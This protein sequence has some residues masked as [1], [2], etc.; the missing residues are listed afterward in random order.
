LKER[1]LMDEKKDLFYTNLLYAA[2]LHDIGKFWQRTN[3]NKSEYKHPRNLDLSTDNIGKSGAHSKWSAEFFDKYLELDEHSRDAVLF[4]H[5]Q[6]NAPTEEVRKKALLIQIADRLSSSER[7]E[8]ESGEVTSPVNEPL[9]SIFSNIAN[10]KDNMVWDDQKLYYYPLKNLNFKLGDEAVLIPKAGKKS[11]ISGYNLTPDYTHLWESF[12]KELLKITNK[13]S[14]TIELLMQLLEKYCWAIP[15]AAYKHTPDISLYDHLKTTCAIA[16]CLYQSNQT[17]EELQ[18]LKNQILKHE[19]TKEPLFLLIKGDISGIHNFIFTIIPKFALKT[20][21]G[22]SIFLEFL[23]EG[24]ARTLLSE[25][26]L[27]ITNILYCGGGNFYLLASVKSEQQLEELRKRISFNVLQTIGTELYF[28]IDW[29][30]LT[31]SDFFPESFSR[32]W[33]EVSEKVNIKKHTQYSEINLKENYDLFFEPFEVGGEKKQCT[34]CHKEI[35]QKEIR[36]WEESDVCLLCDSFRTMV[37]SI[38][39]AENVSIKKSN[40]SN[41]DITNEIKPYYEILFNLGTEISF[42]EKEEVI[43]NM[44]YNLLMDGVPKIPFKI[45][46]RGIPYDEKESRIRDLDTLASSSQGAEKLAIVKMDVDSLGKI[47]RFGLKDNNTI[48]RI[49]TLSNMITRFFGGYLDELIRS[50]DKYN[51]NCYTIFAGGDDLLIVGAWSIIY[52]LSYKIYEEFRRFTCTNPNMTLS[53][54]LVLTNK[55]Y[56]IIRAVVDTEEALNRAK[57]YLKTKNSINLFNESFNWDIFEKKE[58]KDIIDLFSKDNYL[59]NLNEYSIIW[60][61]KEL[62]VDM[63]NKGCPR[64]ILYKIANSI[65]GLSGIIKNSL[66]GD[67]EIPKVWRLRYYLRDYFKDKSQ[68][69]SHAECLLKIYEAIIEKNLLSDNE[70]SKISKASVILV[71]VRWAELLTKN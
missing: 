7:K 37:D 9:I 67:L 20:L 17:Y 10:I 69:K 52:E 61:I 51:N 38:K 55:K 62:L 21:K 64:S 5:K 45:I 59:E 28:A 39:T 14:I 66:K 34:I 4:H 71:A 65:K 47:F 46:N 33:D 54:G 58:A 48:S 40:L 57:N 24:I 56:P 30:K 2:L 68:F 1:F 70:E 23:T 35:N 16:S 27:P 42:G 29:I 3:Y 22:R 60:Y 6:E 25:L 13:G 50:N 18:K 36:K 8:K 63:I 19:K 15:Q 12:E 49:S 32:K 53:A 11:V 41:K 31:A 43:N 26:N 44:T